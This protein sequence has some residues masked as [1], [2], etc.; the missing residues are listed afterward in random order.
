MKVWLVEDYR[1]YEPGHL[2]GVCATEEL[3]MELAA[4]Q[5][6]KDWVTVYDM[7]VLTELPPAEPVKPAY[8]V[9]P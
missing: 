5:K 2:F 9:I 4:R 1:P 8:Q 7:D 3:A 6:Y